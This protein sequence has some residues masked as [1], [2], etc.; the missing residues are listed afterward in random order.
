MLKLVP[1]AL[2]VAVLAG[3]MAEPA[4]PT[5][6]PTPMAQ[7]AQPTPI[8]IYVTPAPT[9][10]PT[11]PPTNRPTAA[12]TVAPTPRVTARPTAPP[13]APPTLG[14]TL[15]PGQLDDDYEEVSRRQWASIV[16]SP[17]DHKFDTITVYGCISQFDSGTG[18]D[19]FRAQ[20]SHKK[21]RYW[22]S[23]GD[24]AMFFAWDA[25]DVAD[26]F[27]DDIFRAKVTIYGAYT[28][29]TTMGGRLTV[30]MFQINEIE[31]LRGSC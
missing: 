1:A 25:A 23:D 24:N 29:E 16:R 4:A 26:L 8:V 22:W 11:V 31:Q 21:E 30:P 10:A 9:V 12:P 19:T 28:Y 20:T 2:L 15:R 27:E 18:N 6:A 17:D 13:T 3:C 14:P 5:A 7:V